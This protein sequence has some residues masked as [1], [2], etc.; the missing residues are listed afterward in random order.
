MRFIPSLILAM[1]RCISESS[2]SNGNFQYQ[3]SSCGSVEQ[4]KPTLEYLQQLFWE[5]QDTN[6]SNQ[7]SILGLREF[8]ARCANEAARCNAKWQQT[9]ACLPRTP[10]T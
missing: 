5:N 8:T 6:I 10:E 2:A 1:S 9:V 7:L 4:F 3:A